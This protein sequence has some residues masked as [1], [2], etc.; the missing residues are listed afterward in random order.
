MQQ[1]LVRR[2]QEADAIRWGGGV[3]GN[4]WVE[5]HILENTTQIMISCAKIIDQSKF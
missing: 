3:V 5:T 2:A 4:S 1:L